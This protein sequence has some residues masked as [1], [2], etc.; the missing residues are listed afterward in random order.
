MWCFEHKKSGARC[1]RAGV[2]GFYRRP[3]IGVKPT[4]VSYPLP[5]G[6]DMPHWG[7]EES[8]DEIKSNARNYNRDQKETDKHD[9]VFFFLYFR[10]SNLSFV[11]F[12]LGFPCDF[13]DL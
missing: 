7:A 8:D 3:L 13:A 11:V 10:V 5:G 2:P 6:P 1:A 12:T 9:V 4:A